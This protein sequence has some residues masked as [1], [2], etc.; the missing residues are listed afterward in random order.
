MSTNQLI[1]VYFDKIREDTGGALASILALDNWSDQTDES[2]CIEKFDFDM[3]PVFLSPGTTKH[4]QQLDVQF[5]K[6][7]KYFV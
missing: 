5:F 4:L 1:G 2:V 7:Y 6:Y 3:E